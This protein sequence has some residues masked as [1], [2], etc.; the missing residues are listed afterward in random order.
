MATLITPGT[1]RTRA[2]CPER[3]EKNVCG[4]A[5]KGRDERSEKARLGDRNGER[6]K[7]ECIKML[8]EVT[9]GPRSM[10]GVT[11]QPTLLRKEF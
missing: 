5:H 6:F 4:C 8:P 3:C 10:E 11:L 1:Y 2:F 9:L 7:G